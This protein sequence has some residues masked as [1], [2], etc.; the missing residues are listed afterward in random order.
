MKSGFFRFPA[1]LLLTVYFGLTGIRAQTHQWTG[2]SGGNW[3]DPAN[4]V[5]GIPS[6]DNGPFRILIF[7]NANDQ[8]SNN[9]ITPG[10]AG[11][12]I[13]DI[14][15]SAGAGAY[16]ITGNSIDMLGASSNTTDTADIVNNSTSTQTF[17]LN[18]IARGDY[19]TALVFN[20]AAGDIVVNGLISQNTPSHVTK[21]GSHTLTLNHANTY[22]GVTTI[23]GGTLEAAILADGGIA[24]SIGASSGTSTNLVFN[25]G[26]LYY[27]GDTN[28]VT[29]RSFV[30]GAS[31]GTLK[32]K[33]GVQATF[34]F[35]AG[36]GSLTIADNSTITLSATGS[37]YTGATIINNGAT[38]IVG[39]L[40]N[41]GVSSSIGS[42]TSDAANLV[43]NGGTLQFTGAAPVG[44]D[45][46]LTLGTLGGTLSTLT[47]SGLR[48]DGLFTGGGPLH[49]KGGGYIALTND[50]NDFTGVATVH[51]GAILEVRKASVLGEADAD[52]NTVINSGGVLNFNP[53]GGNGAGGNISVAEFITVN[54]GGII[55]NSSATNTLTSLVTLSGD[56]IFDI[57][58]GTLNISSGQLS[59]PGGFEKTGNGTLTLSGTNSFAG[60][61]TIS[62]GILSVGSF[63]GPLGTS[64]N[65]IILNGGSFRYTGGADAISRSFTLT[66]LGGNLNAAAAFR[67][68]GR[69]TG[70]GPLGITGSSYVAFS[71][72]T[73][74]YT[75]ITTIAAGA[76]AYLRVNNAL[77]ATG[78]ANRTEVN[79]SVVLDPSGAGGAMGPLNVTETFSFNNN[80]T[81]RNLTLSNTLS[82]PVAFTSGV[83]KGD[84][85]DNT[86]LTFDTNISGDGG[87]TLNNIN[88]ISKNGRVLF[89]GSNTYS[90]P[91]TLVTGHLQVGHA[92]VGSLTSAT[93]VGSE[94][95]LSG[96]GAINALTILA[97]TL[98]PGD[99]SGA[100]VGTLTLG[101]LALKDGA[102][103]LFKLT[104]ADTTI[105]NLSQLASLDDPVQSGAN[106]FVQVTN[107]VSSDPD[108]VIN[109]QL[110]LTGFTLT[111]GQV[112]DLFD[113]ASFAFAGNPTYNVSLI[114]GTLS[115]GLAINTS[116]FSDAGIIAV[117]VVP[118]PARALLLLLA[119]TG[120]NL[121]RQRSAGKAV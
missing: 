93:E 95:T 57:T 15:F 76:A 102:T 87:F 80:S 73:S 8:T 84:V 88:G 106:D 109:L 97:G 24:S 43:F 69:I 18:L 20:T 47:G 75:G 11:V 29:N 35:V 31:G 9:D 90:G 3:S 13:D 53:N 6:P 96:S 14:T 116:R 16:V 82:G 36:E 23:N 52:S 60:D 30:L 12:N 72:N 22:T 71:N 67:S 32:T 119:F 70:D 98:K 113:A 65:N 46:G 59:G 37:T 120:L 105:A 79:G 17:E 74:D 42:A 48:M 26:T 5:G 4:W 56:A 108:A 118:K 62:A 111:E 54:A 114:G 58:G 39:A 19:T 99:D 64:T 1:L 10:A 117:T 40:N 86:T 121:R 38:L 28:V 21:E 7:S 115:P 91:T 66:S 27:T 107:Q 77:G 112:F 33:S 63:F 104:T 25:G 101:D 50:S 110:D 44:T 78:S 83:I 81:V 61:I 55:R 51:S 103:L 34:N 41:G 45:R 49:I 92:G 85:S 94:A 100:S 68:A 89:I 2:S